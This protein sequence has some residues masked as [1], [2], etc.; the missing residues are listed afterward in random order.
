M[1]TIAFALFLVSIFA[2]AASALAILSI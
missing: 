1:I 2:A